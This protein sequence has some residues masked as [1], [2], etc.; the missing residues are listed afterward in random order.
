M[1]KKGEEVP[2]WSNRLCNENPAQTAGARKNFATLGCRSYAV[3]G[4]WKMMTAHIS[5]KAFLMNE[6]MQKDKK[7]IRERD[8]HCRFYFCFD[9]FTTLKAV[10]IN[11]CV[12]KICSRWMNSSVKWRKK[13]KPET[14][15]NLI[16]VSCDLCKIACAVISLIS[17]STFDWIY[18]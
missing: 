4:V 8:S 18:V 9:S 14:V 5:Q 15:F 13:R 16:A 11:F 2:L 10:R 7:R 6:S 17:H 1:L 3:P 12:D